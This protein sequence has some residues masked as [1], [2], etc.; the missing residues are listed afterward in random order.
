MNASFSRVKLVNL[1]QEAVQA[2]GIQV[3]LRRTGAV[4]WDEVASQ[5]AYIPVSYSG[6]MIDY[7]MAYWTNP[8]AGS[9]AVD[10]SIIIMHDQRPCGIWPLSLRCSASELQLGSNGGAIEPPLFI[11]NLSR[12]TAKQLTTNCQKFLQ[13]L[14]RSLGLEQIV[15]LE[16]FVESK[17][18][19]SD[20]YDS[21]LSAGA[22]VSVRHEL[23]TNLE[24]D[25]ETIWGTI[26]RRYRSMINSGMKLWQIEL[27]DHEDFLV[28]N[29]YRELH[30][31]VAGRI[32]RNKESWDIQHKAIASGNAFLI[33]LR[34]AT[35]RMIG[36]GL[37]H[38]TRDE[39]V[40]AVGA[41]DRN[42]FDKPISHVVQYRAIEIMK[43]KGVRWYRIGQ[44]PYL[45]ELPEP[46]SKELAIAD[47][48][49][50][51]ASHLMPRYLINCRV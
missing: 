36:G 11:R 7:Q 1:F 6:V 32:T 43:R 21:F 39:G 46:T 5:I 37:F 28:W 30:I 33:Y 47:F 3:Q 23:F 17:M 14:G 38:Y 50:G 9:E 40:Y 25:S 27:L 45:G 12:K 2:C 16:Q 35:G 29:E 13:F 24:L 4:D 20:W 51:F 48:K 41:Y 10:L 42:M 22:T 44:R 49:Q 19:L 15:C 31:S 26:R 18:G 8:E 34:D